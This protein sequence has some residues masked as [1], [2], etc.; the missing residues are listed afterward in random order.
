MTSKLKLF[1]AV[2]FSCFLLSPALSARNK[3]KT[4]TVTLISFNDF[5]GYFVQDG[6]APGASALVQSVLDE[7]AT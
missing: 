3:F 5:H 6:V 2:W 4:D 1:I 7:K